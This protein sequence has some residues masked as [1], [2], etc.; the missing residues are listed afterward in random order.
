MIPNKVPLANL[1]ANLVNLW[2]TENGGMGDPNIYTG[3]FQGGV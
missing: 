3:K 2:G 1:M